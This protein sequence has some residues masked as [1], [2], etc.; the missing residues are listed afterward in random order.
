[1]AALED[2]FVAAMFIS[3]T[4]PAGNFSFDQLSLLHVVDLKVFEDF[5]SVSVKEFAEKLLRVP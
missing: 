3:Q 2:D 5:I 4:D 1:V